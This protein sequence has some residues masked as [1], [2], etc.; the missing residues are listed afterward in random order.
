[1][2]GLGGKV[3][4]MVIYT[5]GSLGTREGFDVLGNLCRRKYVMG[6]EMEW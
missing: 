4:C 3:P 2:M 5:L 6:G 1:M